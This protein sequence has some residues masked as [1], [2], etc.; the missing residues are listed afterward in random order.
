MVSADQGLGKTTLLRHFE[1]RLQDRSRSLLANH[2]KA[3]EVLSTLLLANGGMATT[4]DLRVMQTQIDEMLT[5]SAGPEKPFILLLDYDDEDGAESV[6]D[7]VRQLASLE[8]FEKGLLR[9]LIVIPSHFAARLQSSELNREIRPV[10]LLP[11]TPTEVES[12]IQY[13]LR[14]VGWKGSPLFTA[15]ACAVIAERSFGKPLA[16]NE[17]CFEVLQNLFK[18]R[19]GESDSAS[20]FKNGVRVARFEIRNDCRWLLTVT[21]TAGVAT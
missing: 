11:L 19:G 16:I 12:Y 17:I 4:D 10:A 15:K 13:R 20:G 1:R 8:S 21:L 14:L 6:L 18:R 5:A 2:G 9:I 7:I 3:I